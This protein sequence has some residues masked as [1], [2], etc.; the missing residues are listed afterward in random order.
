MTEEWGGGDLKLR[1]WKMDLKK[2][3]R[4]HCTRIKK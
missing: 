1:D 4:I 3:S 2:S